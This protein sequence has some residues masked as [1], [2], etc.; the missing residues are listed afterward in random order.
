MALV[1]LREAPL[2][3]LS[4]AGA[5]LTQL[6]SVAQYGDSSSDL[7]SSDELSEHSSM[8]TQLV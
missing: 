8:E 2:S 5:P 4:I 3:P 7:K 6:L 1:L